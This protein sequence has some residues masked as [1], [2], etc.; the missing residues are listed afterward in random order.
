MQVVR[1]EREHALRGLDRPVQPTVERLDLAKVIEP[2]DE[3]R[4][5]AE[6]LLSRS[7]RLLIAPLPQ[8]NLNLVVQGG[9]LLSLLADEPQ[10]A[11]DVGYDVLEPACRLASLGGVWVIGPAAQKTPAGAQR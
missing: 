11:V 8:A 7:A 5:A 10:L 3:V 1:I 9:D 6:Q 4:P 2:G